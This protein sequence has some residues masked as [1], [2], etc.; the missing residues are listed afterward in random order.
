MRIDERIQNIE[1]QLGE[2]LDDDPCHSVI[3]ENQQRIAEIYYR[4]KEKMIT[5]EP[6]DRI[7]EDFSQL[8]GQVQQIKNQN[9]QV[10]MEILDSLR[11]YIRG[12][13][14]NFPIGDY[15][16]E[17][18]DLYDQV[19]NLGQFLNATLPIIFENQNK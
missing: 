16:Q 7:P 19:G 18:N 10:V 8:I 13:H 6:E 2:I 4:A 14:K 11:S 3:N 9:P 12:F 5:S 17:W 1:G 15:N